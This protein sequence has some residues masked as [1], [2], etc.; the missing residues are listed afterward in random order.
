M[1]LFFVE[2]PFQIICA[3][4]ARNTISPDEPAHLIVISRTVRGANAIQMEE[5]I[6]EFKW[7]SVVRLNIA[8][9]GMVGALWQ[10]LKFMRNLVNLT[11]H[12]EVQVFIGEYKLPIMHFVGNALG[13]R[14]SWLLDDGVATLSL[15]GDIDKGWNAA[16][17]QG[18]LARLQQLAIL[19]FFQRS[20][21]VPPDQQRRVLTIFK[22]QLGKDERVF[23]NDLSLLKA[24]RVVPRMGGTWIIGQ[25]LAEAEICDLETELL[26]IKSLL[27]RQN[28]EVEHVFYCPHRHETPEKLRV[29]ERRFGIKIRALK[30]PIEIALLQAEDL[31]NEV[32]GLFSTALFTIKS[33]AIEGVSVTAFEPPSSTWAK[34]YRMTTNTIYRAF[35]DMDIAVRRLSLERVNLPECARQAGVQHT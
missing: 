18:H 27:H 25:K 31:P 2:S 22:E 29:I 11:R 14:Q 3:T 4:Q 16:S 12:A 15:I 7:R 1:R 8:D 17:P 10:F 24:K 5:L 33:M 19:L 28:A 32:V 6:S 9:R 23:K 30:M 35:R 21:S 34:P 13:A 20:V 26:L